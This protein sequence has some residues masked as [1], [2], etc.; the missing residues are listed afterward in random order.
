MFA[1]AKRASLILGRRSFG[2][3]VRSLQEIEV[4]VGA[5]SFATHS[6]YIES[7]DGHFAP[8]KFNIGKF[9]SVD[10]PI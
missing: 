9:S 2:A 3:S 1:V 8:I 10:M 5:S 7:L 6:K 4:D